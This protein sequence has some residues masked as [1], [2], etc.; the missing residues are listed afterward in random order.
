MTE[1][2]TN[3]AVSEV[4]NEW[5]LRPWTAADEAAQPVPETPSFR[6]DGACGSEPC[7]CHLC[8]QC[9]EPFCECQSCVWCGEPSGSQSYCSR[10]CYDADG[11]EGF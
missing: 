6:C 11:G 2:A 10:D 7:S 5:G 4:A 3:E 1:S 9:G 8:A